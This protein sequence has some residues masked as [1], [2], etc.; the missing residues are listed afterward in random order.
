MPILTT[1]ILYGT[2]S[3]HRAISQEKEIKG[4]QIT[5]EEGKLCM[6]E[7]DIYI[8]NPKDT[9]KNLLL[10][11]EFTKLKDTKSIYKNQ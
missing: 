5:K 2:G 9:T 1:P 4:I 6:F 3:P 11:S 7:D 8:E 10:I